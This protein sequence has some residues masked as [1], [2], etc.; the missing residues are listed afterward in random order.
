VQVHHCKARFDADHLAGTKLTDAHYDVVLGGDEPCDVFKPDGSPLVKYRPRWFSEDLCRAVL[1]ACRKAATVTTNRG[2]AT[3]TESEAEG[4]TVTVRKRQ[5][6]SDGTISNTNIAD[7]V[8]SGIVGY[9]D[10]TPRFPFCRQTSFIISEAAA[11][12]RFLPYIER[13]DEGFRE[14]M[15]DRWGVQRDYASRTAAD[16]VIP[17]STFTTVTVNKNFQTATH[18]DAGDLHSGFGVMSCL[19]NDRYDGAYLV[20]PSYRVALDFAHG[21][22]CLADVHEWHSNTSFTQ[23]RPG[24]E[25]ITLIFYYREKMIHCKSAVEEVEWA[26]NRKPG[27]PMTK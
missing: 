4:K 10:R 27:E 7:P 9:F 16:W 18:K 17:Q 12:K 1:P 11:W 21:S 19:R 25:R 26:K 8:N 5:R 22:L 24:Y 6:K 3:G 14:F 20:F 15:P 2:Y 23:M 13:A